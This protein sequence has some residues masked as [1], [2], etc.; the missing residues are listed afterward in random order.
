MKYSNFELNPN[1]FKTFKVLTF[2]KTIRIKF[3]VE[4][5]IKRGV[6]WNGQGLDFVIWEARKYGIRMIL[7]LVNNYKDYGGRAQYVRWAEAAGDQI[8]N[9]DDFYTNQLINTY[10][11][12]HLQVSTYTHLNIKLIYMF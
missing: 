9:D 12:N 11:K 1:F 10:Y 4:S 2:S 3:V 5:Y 7:S 8:H 6:V